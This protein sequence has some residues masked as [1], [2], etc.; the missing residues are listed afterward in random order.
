M[1]AKG[2][3]RRVCK[4][5]SACSFQLSVLTPPRPLARRQQVI[6]VIHRVV[7]P[8]KLLPLPLLRIVPIASEFSG[9]GL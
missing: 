3:E 8:H 1:G 5:M 9:R 6:V 4:I 2:Q 7:P